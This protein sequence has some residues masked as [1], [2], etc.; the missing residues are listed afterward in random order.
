M[1]AN[2]L[3]YTYHASKR[4]SSVQNSPLGLL[5]NSNVSVAL[6]NVN[7]G[8]RNTVNASNKMRSFIA[9]S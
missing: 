6:G 1:T 5:K 3:T 9:I 8:M 4:P 7:E 2:Y